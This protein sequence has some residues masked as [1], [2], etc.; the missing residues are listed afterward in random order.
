VR[1]LFIIAPILSR[2]TP[3]HTKNDGHNCFLT[4]RWVVFGH[5]FAAIAGAG[6]VVDPVARRNLDLTAS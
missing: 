2:V 1:A 3:A 5:H 4:T 6:L